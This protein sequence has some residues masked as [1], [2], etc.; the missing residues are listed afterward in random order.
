MSRSR[1][2]AIYKEGSGS[3]HRQHLRRKVKRAQRTFFRSN[4]DEIAEGTKVIPDGRSIVNDYDYCDYIS[5]CEHISA[6]RYYQGVLDRNELKERLSR[7]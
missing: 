4:I 5:D 6:S 1:K 7:K 2:K 3:K